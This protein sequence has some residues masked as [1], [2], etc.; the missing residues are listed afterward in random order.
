MPEP[1][2]IV[3]DAAINRKLAQRVLAGAGYNVRSVGDAQ[4]ALKEVEEFSPRLVLTD[5]RLEGM[6]GLALTHQIKQDPRTRGIVVI[7]VTGCDTEDV[8]RAAREAGCDD[9]LVK[10]I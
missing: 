10:P 8:R 5:L 4:S 1:I 3:D 9:F 2:L 6:D 7:A